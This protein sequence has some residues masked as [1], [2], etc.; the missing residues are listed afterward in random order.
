MSDSPSLAL[1]AEARISGDLERA[2]SIALALIDSP[3]GRQALELAALSIFESRRFA[4]LMT[5]LDLASQRGYPG[6]ALLAGV[7]D[8]ALRADQFALI[9]A[10][11]QQIPPENP[12][13][14]I[15]A[16]YVGCTRVVRGD[17]G[18]ALVIFGYFRSIVPRYMAS[19]PFTSDNTLNVIYRQAIL[20]A[21]PAEIDA[22]RASAQSLPDPVVEFKF[23]LAATPRRSLVCACAD[24]GYAARFARGL[25]ESVAPEDAL[26]LHIVDPTEKTDL[27]IEELAGLLG[28]GRFGWSTSRDPH[29]GTPTAYAC[30]RFFVS[31]RLLA[32]YQR[33]LIVIDIDLRVKER[34]GELEPVEPAFDFGCFKTGRREPSSVYTALLM[35]MTP[36]TACLEFL[37]AVGEFCRF[38]LQLKFLASTWLLDQ[39]ALY[40][41]KYYFAERRPQF[42]FAVINATSKSDPLDFVS[43]VTTDAEKYDMR[44]QR[45][46]ERFRR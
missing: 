24:A 17:P 33:P 32:A 30:A 20:L 40:S 12:L 29:Y 38:G 6:P 22:R 36:T 5:V 28:P 7:L 37:Q 4:D 42:R 25:A 14:P 16:Y 26:H 8:D 11:A 41:L 18:A 39:A 1:A 21:A 43:L 31:P 15:G 10:L 35:I 23:G 34:F 19:V 9:E 45:E 27:L 44:R 2:A 46:T 13:H 3:D